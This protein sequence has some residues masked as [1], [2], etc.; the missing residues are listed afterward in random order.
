VPADLALQAERFAVGRQQELDRRGVEADAVVQPLHAVLGVDPLDRHHRHQ[1]LDLADLRRIAG[2]EGFDEVGARRLD[3][4]VDPV[5]RDVDARQRRGV[6][7]DDLVDLRDDDPARERV[8]S[9]IAGV[10][11]VFGP[12]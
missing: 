3:H 7:V 2:E 9:T 6:A 4:E 12:V 10:S 1:H 8:A 11:S 5:A